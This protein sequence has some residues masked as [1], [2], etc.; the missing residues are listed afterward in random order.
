[1]SDHYHWRDSAR[2]AKL[3]KIDAIVFIPLVLCCLDFTIWHF[4]LSIG[5]VVFFAILSY[6]KISILVF[7]RLVRALCAGSIKVRNRER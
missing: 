3:F 4:V 2:Q 6:F 5:L 1:M 7:L